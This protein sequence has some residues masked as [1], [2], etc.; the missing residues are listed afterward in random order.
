MERSG[1]RA[2]RLEF[3]HGDGTACVNTYNISKTMPGSLRQKRA[4]QYGK[5]L[6]SGTQVNCYCTEK[7]DDPGSCVQISY[8]SGQSGD[9]CVD[10]I[11]KTSG[12]WRIFRS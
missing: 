6:N 9:L 3:I 7:L 1:T 10:L 11:L 2:A 5:W 12:K 8:A 4:D